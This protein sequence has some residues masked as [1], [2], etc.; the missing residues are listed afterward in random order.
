MKLM[1][2]LYEKAAASRKSEEA[3]CGKLSILRT[4][5][6]MKDQKIKQLETKKAELE[7]QIEELEDRPVEVA[8]QT[9]D[10]E[11]DKLT[12][13]FKEELAKHE[14][15]AARRL[16]EQKEFYR[17]QIKAL[18]DNLAKES[19]NAVAECEKE[20][21]DAAKLDCMIRFVKD[22]MNKLAKLVIVLDDTQY[23]RQAV[24]SIDDSFTMLKKAAEGCRDKEVN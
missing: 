5:S 4:D 10:E 21:A 16:E 23:A 18:S 13:Q 9:N 22:S 11:I 24:Y 12:A 7:Y 15:D 3:A 17:G 2:T 8:V 14:K 20:A 1:I 6:E 19:E